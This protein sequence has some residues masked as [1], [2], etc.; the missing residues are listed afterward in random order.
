MGNGMKGASVGFL[1]L[2]IPLRLYFMPLHVRGMKKPPTYEGGYAVAIWLLETL[3][4]STKVLSKRSRS[5]R[6]SR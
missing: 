1:L 6:N 3:N 4:F 5:L 2:A